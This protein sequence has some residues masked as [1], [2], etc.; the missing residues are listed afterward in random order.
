M[1]GS[2]HSQD[3]DAVSLAKDLAEEVAGEVRDTTCRGL[4]TT[5]AT[6]YRRI[7][8]GVV[9]PRTMEAV[10][11]TMAVCRRHGAPIVSRGAGTSL[12]GQTANTAVVIE[13]PSALNVAITKFHRQ[14]PK[15]ACCRRCARRRLIPGSLPAASAAAVR[16]WKEPAGALCTLPNDGQSLQPDMGE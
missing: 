8:I 12:A 4:Y 6:N 5:D 14:T 16:S 1:P 2:S 7:P 15:S 10:E 13:A 9:I 3:L 11:N